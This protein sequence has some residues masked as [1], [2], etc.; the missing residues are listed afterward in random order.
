VKVGT[1]VYIVQEQ[2]GYGPDGD[3]VETRKIPGKITEIVDNENFMVTHYGPPH[4]FTK[5]GRKYGT[6]SIKVSKSRLAVRMPN[7]EDPMEL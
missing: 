5:A 6:Y 2:R 7:P 4:H 1:F 3:F